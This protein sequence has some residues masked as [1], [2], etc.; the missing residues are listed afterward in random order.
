MSKCV[1]RKIF[2]LNYLFAS[3]FGAFMIA[4]AFAYYNYKFSQYKFINFEKLVFYKKAD[5]F[6]PKDDKYT[7][8]MYSSKKDD[9]NTLIKKTKHNFPILAIDMQQEK[10]EGDEKNVIFV[11][12]GVNTL[13][14]FI[15]RFNIFK[16]PCIFEIKKQNKY[17]YKQ[18]SKIIN[19]K[20]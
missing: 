7:I 20:G 9:V 6:S 11:T 2:S 18:D 8:L 5:I 1:G 15:Q 19:L 14:A 17:L 10:R 4:G 3:F 12:S 16:L 13:I